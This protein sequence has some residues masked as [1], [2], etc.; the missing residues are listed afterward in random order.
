MSLVIQLT[1][2]SKTTEDKT[3]KDINCSDIINNPV[4]V[5]YQ[6]IKNRIDNLFDWEQG[7]RILLPQYGNV[8]QKIKYEPLSEVSIKNAENLIRKMFSYEPEVRLSTINITPNYDQN[9]M[10]ISCTYE[11]QNLNSKVT[12]NLTITTAST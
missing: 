9:E 11:I 7:M 10:L 6:S 8:L 2:V 1:P 5:D 4:N 3:Y 12:K